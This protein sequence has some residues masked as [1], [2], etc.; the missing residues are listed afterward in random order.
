MTAATAFTTISLFN[1]LQFPFAFLPMGLAQYSQSLVSTRRL[2]NFFVSEELGEY[3]SR[4]D[5]KDNIA[6]EMN[7]LS[8]CW[9]KESEE[10]D[11]V[12]EEEEGTD[13]I[14]AMMVSKIDRLDPHEQTLRAQKEAAEAKAADA[15]TAEEKESQ[16]V[17]A[18]VTDKR[19]LINRSAQTLSDINL[20][21]PKGAL[22]AVVGALGS[23][24]SSFLS[25]ILGEMHAQTGTVNVVGSVAYCEQRPW[26]LNATV[27]Q[28]ILFGEPMNLK[29][30]DAAI[31]AASLEDDIK[32]LPGGI[33]TEI[34]ERGI[35]LSG[36][37]KARVALARAV[38]KNCDAYL[39]D[40]PLSAVGKHN[41]TL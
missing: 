38:Y 39:L 15:L 33:Q 13:K 34:G 21:I 18:A 17:A 3:V 10:G 31:H 20:V 16:A 1:L 27:E 8:V 7:D 29:R 11:G 36:G 41:Y 12:V 6:I 9:V 23:G 22:V 26:I 40:D 25:A 35:N 2:L 30:F 32:V 4:D 37:Q 28:N 5:H 24:K 19:A 14:E